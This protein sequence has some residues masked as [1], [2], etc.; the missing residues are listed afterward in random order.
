MLTSK[1]RAYLRGLANDINAIF[2]IGRDGIND[3]LIQQISDALEAREL[4]KVRVLK[5][6]PGKGQDLAPTV[7]NLTDAEVV[8][9]IGNIFVLY[10]RS[11][12]SPVI[13]LPD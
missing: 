4:V 6:A 11:Q 5:N 3:N 1:Q 9:A 13:E 10:R 8:Q 12:D 2:Q 7:A